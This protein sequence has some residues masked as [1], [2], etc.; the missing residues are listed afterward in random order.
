MALVNNFTT[1]LSD[2]Q[3]LKQ[4]AKRLGYVQDRG[5]QKGEGSIRQLLEAIIAGEVTPVRRKQKGSTQ[6]IALSKLEEKG[7]IVRAQRPGAYTPFSPVKIK[8][9]PVSEMLS[10]ER[11]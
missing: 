1:Q 7:F 6:T 11:R 10:R 5:Q 9:E 8:G 4:L 3:K 2:V